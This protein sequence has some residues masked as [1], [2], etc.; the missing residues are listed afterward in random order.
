M[1]ARR[2]FPCWDEPAIKAN[3]TITI[4]T[5]EDSPVKYHAISN[6]KINEDQSANETTVFNTSPIMPAYLVAFVVSNYANNTND[7]FTVWTKPHA[8]DSTDFALKIGQE[9]LKELESYTNINYK[10]YQGMQKMDQ[11]SIPDFA[12]GAMENWGLVT[13]R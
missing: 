6:M 2:A 10:E 3:F 9:A 7:D 5:P 8:I 1:G 13:Y 11:I 12:A 4:I